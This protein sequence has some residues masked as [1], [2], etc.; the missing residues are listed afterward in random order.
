MYSL[1]YFLLTLVTCSYKFISQHDDFEWYNF[2][3]IKIPLKGDM[4]FFQIWNFMVGIRKSLI[5][6]QQSPHVQTKAFDILG[7]Q[8]E[9]EIIGFK[10]S[11]ERSKMKVFTPKGTDDFTI[12]IDE[13]VKIDRV[14]VTKPIMAAKKNLFI[15]KEHTKNN[16]HSAKPLDKF[17][18]IISIKKTDDSKF[19]LDTLILRLYNLV[20]FSLK[21]FA[22]SIKRGDDNELIVS[23]EFEYD[24]ELVPN[25]DS[26][27]YT[28]LKSSTIFWYGYFGKDRKKVNDWFYKTLKNVYLEK[29]TQQN[30][31]EIAHSYHTTDIVIISLSLTILLILFAVVIKMKI[32]HKNTYEIDENDSE[33]DAYDV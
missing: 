31:D 29:N 13:L 16:N 3:A 2:Y 5:R 21:L 15:E 6:E 28:K 25:S 23:S 4:K 9:F 17:P 24:K 27:L 22:V 33:S 8:C 18:N 11:Y 10:L 19:Q 26:E 7:D 12:N 14:S 1:F 30:F 20:D 32:I